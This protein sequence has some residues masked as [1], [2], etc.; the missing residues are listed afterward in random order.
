[1]TVHECNLDYLESWTEELSARANRVRNLIGNRHWLTDGHH[2]EVI[3]REF[4]LRYLPSQL[5]IGSGFIK[6][7]DED[8]CSTEIDILISDNLKHP[9]YFNEGGI[10]ILPPSS[11]V[12]Y[13]E[14]KSTFSSTS[15][16]SALTG[17]SA[18]QKSLN[19]FCD[20]V[21]RCICF[22]TIDRDFNSFLSTVC[23]EIKKTI[24]DLNFDS[25]TDVMR[26]LPIC[27]ASF[28]T[29]VVFLKVSSVHNSISLSFFEFE[30]LSASI[31]FSDLFEHVRS[32]FG[33]SNVGELSEFIS[34]MSCKNYNQREIKL[35]E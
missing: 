8:L 23:S 35:N 11:V 15:L 27:I 16:C 19:D 32:H 6:A 17:V 29:Y 18:S 22:V 1:M 10:Q 4:L 20:S 33:N 9:A 5:V 12:A 13:I 14:M 24:A 2:K 28:D 30:K 21:W 3:V 7:L 26:R 34:G 31:S 25:A